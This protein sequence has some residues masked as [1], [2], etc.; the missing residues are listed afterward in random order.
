[1]P[2]SRRTAGKIL[3]SSMTDLSNHSIFYISFTL[4][5]LLTSLNCSF[6]KPSMPSWD[7]NVS[8]PLINKSYTMA[9]LA[10][11]ESSISLDSTGNLYFEVDADLDNYYIGDELYLESL[12]DDFSLNFGS[13]SID[14]PSSV[15]TSVSLSE[16]FS[17][18]EALHGL[19][20]IV[21]SFS[22][23]TDK[24]SLDPY[25]TFSYVTIETGN[26]SLQVQN[27]LAVPLGSPLTL[28][29]WNTAQD[30][31][32]SSTTSSSQIA[33]GGSQIFLVDLAGKKIPNQLSVRMTGDSPGSSGAAVLVDKNSNFGMTSSIMNLTVAEALA[34]IP[35]QVISGEEQLSITD[36]VVVMDAKIE[37]GSVD[38]TISGNF[39]VDAWV[40][41]ELPD[42]FSPTGSVLVDS[43]FISGSIPSSISINLYNYSFQ[44][45]LA[46]F[47]QQKVR[48]FW[49]A[50]TVDSGSNRVLVKSSDM[51]NVNFNVEEI[52]FYQ[53]TGKIGQKEFDIEQD[54]IEFDIPIDLDSLFF[55]TARLELLINN[56]IN[57]PANIELV[58][59]GEN[60]SGTKA[61]MYINHAIQ[62]AS[63]PGLPTASIIVLDNQ[64]SSIKDFISIVPNLLRV[65]GKIVIGDQNIA[66]T[67][68]KNDFVTGSIKITAP[69]ALRLASQSIET[70]TIELKIDDEVKDKIIDNLGAGVLFM[71]IS[72]HLPIG[73]SLEIVFS[74][75][76]TNLYQNPILEI[77]A[78]RANAAS[79]DASGLVQSANT[80]ESTIGLSEE[81]M[82]IFLLSPLH[83]GIRISL[84]GTNGR[85]VTLRGSDYIQ[86]KSYSRIN[87]TVNRD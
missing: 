79:V 69:F 16:I 78:I 53:L 20:V 43:V 72:N 61:Q 36:S 59:E 87:V 35:A 29:I 22:F 50:R 49:R 19:T 82:R 74:Q 44:P 32:I 11:K 77:S 17:Q 67:V 58:I 85:F 5:F 68:S 26:I 31:L 1:M 48:F 34:E 4:A 41:Y 66:G 65:S 81:Q 64:N 71:E 7:T 6:D 28:E 54:D 37:S 10:E 18:A 33:A 83:A 3:F 2:K 42:F 45:E 13:F 30:T 76:K 21:P 25:D 46:G 57:F 14:P 15:A 12:Q 63:A 47:G 38:F 62:A 24:K 70:E 75:D 55:E 60:E 51:I 23:Q 80:A 73:A 84:D 52:R 9:E 39:A 8:I 86:I 56:G 40:R 27:N